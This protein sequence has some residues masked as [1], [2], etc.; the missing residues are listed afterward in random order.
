MKLEKEASKHMFNPS[1]LMLGGIR[2]KLMQFFG[3]PS[4]LPRTSFGSQ[5]KAVTKVLG[6]YLEFHRSSHAAIALKLEKEASN[7]MFNPSSLMLVIICPNL[8]QLLEKPVASL[9][10][11]L[12]V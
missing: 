9:E 6:S 10:P 1:S 5:N 4:G 3:D 7:H 8:M 2:Q 11:A 12:E